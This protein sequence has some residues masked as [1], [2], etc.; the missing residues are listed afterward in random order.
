MIN[1][2]VIKQNIGLILSLGA[3]ALIR[4]I[5]KI[6]G[7]IHLLINEQFGSILMTILISLVWLMIVVKKKSQHPIQIL[8]FA[9]ISYAIFATILSAILS[10]ALTGQLQGPL[11]NP[12]ALISII[13]TNII[14]GLIIGVIAIAMMKKGK[15]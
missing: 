10:P 2:E 8:V 15:K 6:T 7:M 11:T 5:M 1:K 13:A 12:S 3:I 9:G 14:W 4:P